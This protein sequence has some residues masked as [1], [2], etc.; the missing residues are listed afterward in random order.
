MLTRQDYLE[1]L[2]Q[3]KAVESRMIDTYAKCM[4][5]VTDEQVLRVCA[6]LLEQEKVHEGLVTE[7]MELFGEDR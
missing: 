6:T 1:Y 2:G 3:I 4:R 7:L 5:E